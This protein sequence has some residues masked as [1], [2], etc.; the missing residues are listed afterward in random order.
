MGNAHVTYSTYNR[1]LFKVTPNE[2]EITKLI[3][4]N[5]PMAAQFA[6]SEKQVLQTERETVW[7][8]FPFCL[9]FHY[10]SQISVG[11]SSETGVGYKIT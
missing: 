8:I 1:L 5:C 7:E 6:T 4:Q 9:A 3:V 11:K 2:S 10:Y